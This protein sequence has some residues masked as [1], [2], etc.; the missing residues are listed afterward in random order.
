L[1][2]IILTI[3]YNENFKAIAYCNEDI[4]AIIKYQLFDNLL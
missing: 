2:P 1:I 4:F 3:Y